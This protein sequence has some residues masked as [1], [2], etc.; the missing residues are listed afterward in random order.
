VL[1]SVILAS[2]L[3]KLAMPWLSHVANV[4]PGIGLINANS[5]IF[6][7]AILMLVTILSGVYPALVVS[8]FT[9]ALALKSKI[10]AASI[11]GISLRRVLVVTQF[12]ISQVLII[13]TIVAVSQMNFVRN[14]DLG[15]NKEAILVIPSYADSALLSRMKPLKQQLMKTPGIVNVSMSSDVP[16][17]DNNWASNFYFNNSGKDVDFPSFLKYGDEDYFATYGLQ[18]LA[19]RPFSARDTMHELVVNE[20]MMKRLHITDPQKMLGKTIRI[21]GGKWL[22]I[23]GVVKD[24]KTNSLREDIKP[25]TISEMQTFYFTTGIKINTSN[26]A[27]T[28]AQVQKLWLS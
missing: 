23:V 6:L 10:N 12:S 16:S 14:A 18:F 22:P 24:F 8:G 20:T 19:G 28:T 1:F 21:G 13:G 3:A 2:L 9:P 4:P 17:S 15:F 26:L 11:G 5:I 7:A 27:Q 25:I